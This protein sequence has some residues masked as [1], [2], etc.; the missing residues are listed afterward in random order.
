MNLLFYLMLLLL[1]KPKAGE[2][3][4]TIITITAIEASDSLSFYIE[5]KWDNNVIPSECDVYRIMA[6]RVRDACATP[7]PSSKYPSKKL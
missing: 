3:V 1:P 4:V 2:R 6:D 5:M 7:V